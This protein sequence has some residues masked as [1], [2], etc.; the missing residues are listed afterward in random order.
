MNLL[1]ELGK[2]KEM[3]SLVNKIESPLR[4][5]LCNHAIA[6]YEMFEQLETRGFK[7]PLIFTAETPM[8]KF[9]AYIDPEDKFSVTDKLSQVSKYSVC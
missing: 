8:K 3:T 5:W 1:H 9:V 4:G 2:N 7:M 6:S